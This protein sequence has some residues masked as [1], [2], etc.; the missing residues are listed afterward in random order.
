MRAAPA[1]SAE[2]PSQ[3]AELA[4]REKQAPRVSPGPEAEVACSELASPHPELAQAVE[5]DPSSLP[6][7]QRPPEVELVKARYSQ[8]PGEP[9]VTQ[10]PQLERQ[11]L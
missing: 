10:P 9:E 11:D 7:H 1:L 5:L 3:R 4:R 2:F 6:P 8:G